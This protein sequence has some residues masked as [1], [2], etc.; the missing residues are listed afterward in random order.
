MKQIKLTKIEGTESSP[1]S[2]KAGEC[3]VGII[4]DGWVFPDKPTVGKPFVIDNYRTSRVTK[5]INDSIFETENSRY[6]WQ[7]VDLSAKKNGR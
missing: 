5:I 3:K 4:E 6:Y 7:Q 2:M 1:S